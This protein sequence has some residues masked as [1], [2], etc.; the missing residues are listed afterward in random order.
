MTRDILSIEARC[1][2]KTRALQRSFQNYRVIHEISWHPTCLPLVQ[3][4]PSPTNPDLH[5]QL[6]LNGIL[7]S[8]TQLASFEQLAVFNS[9]GPRIIMHTFTDN[10]SKFTYKREVKEVDKNST[11]S[12]PKSCHQVGEG[13]Q[14]EQALAVADEPD[15][16][17]D[18]DLV[19]TAVDEDD[20]LLLLL[21]VVETINEACDVQLGSLSFQKIQRENVLL[22][23][24]PAVCTMDHLPYWK[25]IDNLQNVMFKCTIRNLN[26][27]KLTIALDFIVPAHLV[28]AIVAV[29]ATILPGFGVG[30]ARAVAAL[31]ESAQ[32]TVA[33]VDDTTSERFP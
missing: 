22:V 32:F 27:K 6:Y 17:H 16:V 24:H 12:V 9:Q 5:T 1:V 18:T 29:Q 25:R 21:L 19:V 8:G 28:D 30:H 15:D 33:E 26:R 20:V 7:G 14:D 10:V 4:N 23:S 2:P 13:E 31:N 11:L 3:V